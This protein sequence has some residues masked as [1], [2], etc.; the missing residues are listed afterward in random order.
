MKIIEAGYSINLNHEQGIN[1]VL[2]LEQYGRVCYKSE[3]DSNL[4]FSN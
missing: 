3:K 1:M 2:N 4:N